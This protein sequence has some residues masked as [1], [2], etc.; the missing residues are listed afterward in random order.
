MPNYA[1]HVLLRWGGKL[2]SVETWSCGIRLGGGPGSNDLGA[3]E[4]ITEAAAEPV[5]DFWEATH[6][7]LSSLDWV[8]ANAIGSNGK[9]VS[10]TT[11]E[12]TYTPPVT[13][14]G[15]TF[16]PPQC[17]LVVSLR[18]AKSRGRGHA[19]RFYI[20]TAA[21]GVAG[22]GRISQI[23]AQSFAES[24][25]AFIQSIN[26]ILPGYRVAVFSEF[27]Q[28]R[29]NVTHVRVG[30]VI[31]TQRRRRTSIAELPYELEVPGVIELP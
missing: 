31:D 13:K 23:G 25:A 8:K 3:A 17:A 7:G 21:S 22:D 10:D 2:A 30:R 15:S 6:T 18:T 16:L 19:G 11:N 24:A 9:Y 28:I 1:E 12:F 27:D 29:E 20:P 5:Q 14:G 4:S 26:R